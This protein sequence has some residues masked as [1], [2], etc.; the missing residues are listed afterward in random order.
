MGCTS[1]PPESPPVCSAQ[2]EEER[3]SPAALPA[4]A[5]GGMMAM[6]V[7]IPF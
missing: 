1:W 6:E 2:Y 7:R 5:P 4:G 3:G